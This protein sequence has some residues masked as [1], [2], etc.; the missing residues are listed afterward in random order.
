MGE[1]EPKRT[2]PS[3]WAVNGCLFTLITW[4]FAAMVMLFSFGGDCL[5]EVGHPC[6]SDHERAM[7]LVWVSLGAIG[8]NLLGLFLLGWLHARRN[9]RR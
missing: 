4:L 6:P 3:G 1:Q 7:S 9:S 5:P 2:E 8:I